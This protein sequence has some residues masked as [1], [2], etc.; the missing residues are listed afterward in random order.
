MRYWLL[1]IVELF[2]TINNGNRSRTAR[3]SGGTKR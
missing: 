1:K 3:R 2:D